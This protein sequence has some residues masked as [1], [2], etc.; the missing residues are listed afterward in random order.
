MNELTTIS[1]DDLIK[2]L[3]SRAKFIV[4]CAEFPNEDES[5]TTLINGSYIE[6]AGAIHALNRDFADHENKEIYGE[7]DE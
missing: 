4:M 2:E 6:R 7:K 5:F 1:T 3:Q